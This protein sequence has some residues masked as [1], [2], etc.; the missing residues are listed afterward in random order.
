M[1]SLPFA[2]AIL[3]A[4]ASLTAQAT[5]AYLVDSNLDQLFTVDLSTGAATFIAGTLNNGLDTP[6]DLSWRAATNELWTI[7]L[8][9]GEVGT[10]DVTN[11]TFTAVYQTNL[12]GWQ[13]MAWDET[14]QLFFLANQNGSNYML[15]P[16]TG[17]TTLLGA[18][19]FGLITALDTDASGNLF[20]TDFSTGALVSID[21]VTGVATLIASSLTNFQGLGID[22]ATGT[23]Y[24][25]STSTQSL[26]SVDS[27]TGAATLIGA[28]GAGVQFAKGFDLID[29]GAGNY[30]QK[31]RYGTGCNNE[32]ASFYENHTAFDLSNTSLAMQFIGTGYVGIPG[33]T[34]LY[35]PTSAPVAM[36]DDQVLQFSLGWTLPYPGGT[37]TDLW[38]SSNGFVNATVNTLNGCCAFNLTQ[39]LSNG[40]CWAAKWRDLNPSAGG[41]VYFDTDP[42]TGTAYIT[43]DS[44]PDYNTTNANTFQYAFD[45]TGMVEL[46]FGSVAPTAGGTGWSPGMANLDP[47]SMDLSAAAVIITGAN[48]VTPIRHDGSARPV[49]GTG[50][51]LDTSNLPAATVV[52]ATLFGLTELNPGLDL[53]SI[54]MPGCYQYVSIDASQVWVPTGGVGS[55]PFS[56]PNNPA[57]AGVEIKTQGVALVPGVNSLGALSSNGVKLVLDV[58]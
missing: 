19:G 38:I 26:Y 58:N 6:A 20:G 39:F 21:K 51:T 15:D 23:W 35:V 46:R 7:D 43:F 36:A 2:S 8:S 9:G 53:S 44:V 40:P 47:G 29:G 1:Q 16:A 28:H 37:T 54:G 11:G 17:V 42:V 45:S 5:T 32:Y 3:L 25:T 33:T 55:T 12:S 14:S 24:A 31:V 13:G 41:S 49:I 50:I 22:Q 48:D 52:G 10:I 27:T 18:A 56:V 57:F 34:A 4:T 30:A